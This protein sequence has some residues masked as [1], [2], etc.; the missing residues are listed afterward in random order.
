MSVRLERDDEERRLLRGRRLALRADRDADRWLLFVDAITEATRRDW[1]AL[2]PSESS[3]DESALANP[4]LQQC[5]AR[6]RPDE[7][8]EF[9]LLGQCGRRHFSV[10]AALQEDRVVIE[11]ADR[12]GVAMSIVDHGLTLWFDAASRLV[13]NAPDHCLLK[14]PHGDD[15]RIEPIAPAETPAL[16]LRLTVDPAARTIAARSTDP[17]AV[18]AP[19]TVRYGLRIEPV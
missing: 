4:V 19:A 17:A 5:F 10:V 6:V 8:G 11:V 18:A 14:T 15:W 1:L 7:I 13:D 16:G 9:L 2:T 3:D 12:W